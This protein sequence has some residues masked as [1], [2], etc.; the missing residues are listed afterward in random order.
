M[1]EKQKN[2][3]KKAMKTRKKLK[4]KKP[5]F[6]VIEH[7]RHRFLRKKYRKPRGIR[8]KIRLDK[9]SKPRAPNIG[10]RS[11]RDVRG[12]H[13]SGKAE[14]LISNLFELVGLENVVVRMASKTGKRKK[15]EIMKKAKEMG[16]RIL[17]PVRMKL[18]NDKISVKK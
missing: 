18:A 10:W 14:M 8:N 5:W 2:G 11:P 3:N 13:P 4:A 7:N 12:F 6:R 9:K 17:N 1:V 15:L 16:L